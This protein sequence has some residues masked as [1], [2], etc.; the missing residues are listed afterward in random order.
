MPRSRAV[1][2]VVSTMCALSLIWE[3]GASS[4]ASSLPTLARSCSTPWM[5]SEL[6]NSST[7]TLPMILPSF[8]LVRVFSTVFCSCLASAKRTL[9]TLV[10]CGSSARAAWRSAVDLRFR[11]S[12]SME[13]WRSAWAMTRMVSPSKLWVSLLEARMARKISSQGRST[14]FTLMAPETPGLMTKLL[15]TAR[16]RAWSTATMSALCM[17][18]DMRTWGSAFLA[19]RL[20]SSISSGRSMTMGGSASWNWP[21]GECP[22]ACFSMVFQ[23]STESSTTG[24]LGLAWAQAK[25]SVHSARTMSAGEV[26]GFRFIVS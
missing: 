6:L 23:V 7:W 9:A 17:R 3:R 20:A 22:W 18:R 25:S 13:P 5:I 12:R 14:K 24:I 19:S 21:R 26:K 2:L 16:D 4:R 1:S 8:D 11:A 10:T 15:P